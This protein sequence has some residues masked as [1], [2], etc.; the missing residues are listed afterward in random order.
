MTNTKKI[1][2]V[3][4]TRP[5]AIKLA[6]VIAALQARPRQ[7]DTVVC[8][9]GQHREMLLQ[10][11]ETFGIQPQI[12][13]DVM[14]PDQTL[15]DLTAL[16][17]S[18]LTATL[19]A[20]RPDRVIVQGDTTTAFAAALAG[21]YARVPVAHVEAGLRSHDRH[22]PFPEE[23][24]RRLISAIA[25]LHFAPTQGAADALRA[26]A[27]AQAT[28][29]VTGNTIVDALLALRGR[30]ET[31]DGLALVPAAIRG[32]GTDGQPLIL[33]TCHRRESFGDDLAAICRAL[34]R[35]ALGHPD[36]RIVFPVHL[37]PNVRAQVM[38]LLG[39]TPNIALLE[40]VSY[41]SLVYLLSRAVLVLSD[42]GGIQEEAPSFGVPILVLR[43]KTERPE[44]VA[45]GVAQLVG[46]DEELIVDRAGALLAQAGD[47]GAAVIANP[48]GDGRASERIAD[49]L[50]SAS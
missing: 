1:M 48:Y 39:D 20:E 49:I 44:G 43:W 7:F 50:A 36:H 42:S 27:I 21:Y 35:I 5:E 22:N 19:A 45:A 46:A 9:S 33:V 14:R 16:L 30:L 17:I 47:R 41:P 37:N 38:P 3:F 23:I 25:D 24:N 12:N 15:P 29:H 40:P 31:P 10:T 13:L 18:R 11:L 4:G 6:P 32:F 28:I 26:E 34:K 8:S 2:V